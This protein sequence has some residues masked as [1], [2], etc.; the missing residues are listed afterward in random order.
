MK[1][2][3][4]HNLRPGGAKRVLYEQVKRLSKNHLIDIYTFTS[5]ND[6]YF[7]LNNLV[8]NYYEIEYAYPE[9]FPASVIS[10]YW[11]LPKAYQKMA[12]IIN[13]GSYDL[14]YIFP[15]FLTQAPYILRYLKI[16]SVYFCPEPKR[17]FYEKIPRISNKLS[18]TLTYPFRFYLKKIDVDNLKPANT[19]LTLSRYNELNI[20]KYYNRKSIV[21]RLG[22]NTDT[23][24]PQNLLKENMILSVGNF[25]LLKGHDF[26]IKSLSLIPKKIR[27]K[28]IIAGFGGHEQ[29]YLHNLAA[30]LDVKLKLIDSPKDEEL[31]QLYS[32]AA[33]LAFA[34]LKEPLGLVVLEAL[35][36][37]LK[38]LAV[39]DGGVPEIITKKSLGMM[40]KRN[41][42]IFAQAILNTIKKKDDE[43]SIMLR[44]QYV[45]D[46]W[47]WQKSVKQLE[48][49]LSEAK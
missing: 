25:T 29:S 31:N 19:I 22:V 47:N 8:S 14:A 13:S 36:T 32:K 1:I 21:I 48:K 15:C 38:V 2:A 20:A 27:P 5:A 40:V 37:G 3:V 42:K 24:Y 49:L 7:P 11:Q 9:H 28:L 4:V 23:F 30:K 6:R 26:I 41:E 44:R 10:I 16:P 12:N 33:L 46:N 18:Y 45:L 34:A 39:N 43:A 17:E 35:A